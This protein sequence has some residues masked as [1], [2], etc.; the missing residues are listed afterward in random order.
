MRATPPNLLVNDE[1][2][3]LSTPNIISI[4][5]S[6]M[7]QKLNIVARMRHTVGADQLGHTVYEVGD[8]LEACAASGT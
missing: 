7:F 8:Y 4:L 2:K 3:L 1:L 5:Q 6:A